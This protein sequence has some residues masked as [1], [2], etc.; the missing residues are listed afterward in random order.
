MIRFTNV[1][2]VDNGNTEWHIFSASRN[3][4]Q[5]YTGEKYKPVEEV[6]HGMFWAE[7][8]EDIN[9]KDELTC[10]G[11][12]PL[13]KSLYPKNNGGLVKLHLNG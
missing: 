6:Y 4:I 8:I 5:L 9:S 7:N 3:F 13:A 12:R 11:N 1:H 2:D 10:Y